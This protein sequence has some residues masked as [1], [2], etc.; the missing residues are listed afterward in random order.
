MMNDLCRVFIKENKDRILC[1]PSGKYLDQLEEERHQP[2][3][4]KIVL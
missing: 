4:M 1:E 2:V 3:Y